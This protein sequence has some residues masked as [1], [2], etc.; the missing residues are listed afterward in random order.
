MPKFTASTTESSVQSRLNSATPA[1][2]K[3]A[4]PAGSAKNEG[5]K[6]SAK[7]SAMPKPAKIC[8]GSIMSRELSITHSDRSDELRVNRRPKR[9]PAKLFGAQAILRSKGVGGCETFLFPDLLSHAK[10]GAWGA[11]GSRRKEQSDEI[12][13]RCR[14]SARLWSRSRSEE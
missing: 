7:A 13:Q 14:I 9:P 3:K 8:H 11:V 12:N 1:V 4:N 10:E 6:T 2:A 5:V